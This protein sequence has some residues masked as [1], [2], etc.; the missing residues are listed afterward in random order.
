MENNNAKKLCIF[1]GDRF[2]VLDEIANVKEL[3]LKHV[4][5]LKNSVLHK[6]IKYFRGNFTIFSKTEKN[7]ILSKINTMKFDI[8]IS[9]GCPFILPISKIKKTNQLY[10]NVHP[11]YLP[12]FR[13]MHPLN[14]AMLAR[15]KFAGA[16]MHFMNDAIDSGRII[17][18][19]KIPITSDIDLG[20]LYHMIFNLEADVFLTG[21]RKIIGSR[22]KFS[23]VKRTRTDSYYSRLSKDM[24]VDFEKMKS[25]E[26]I[27]RIR[28][29]GVSTQGVSVNIG[30]SKYK[31]FEAERI[32]NKYLI[33]KYSAV[34]SGNIIT[35]YDNKLLIKSC[36]GI[37]KVKLFRKN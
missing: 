22:Y 34:L 8:L 30:K 29:F 3:F 17:C 32:F 5:I 6:R 18:Q 31:I 23:G 24:K 10:I 2:K 27:R 26:I 25:D 20:L 9:N 4:F 21:M 19:E 11:S 13:G 15:S 37:I 1:I 28:A 33:T 35:E 7:E 12:N 16:T 14:G 36:D